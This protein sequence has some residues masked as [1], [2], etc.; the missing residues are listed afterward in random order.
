LDGR[1]WPGPAAHRYEPIPFHPAWVVAAILVWASVWFS[2][3]IASG[4]LFRI[5]QP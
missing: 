5:A 2:M 1:R 4:V 3:Y